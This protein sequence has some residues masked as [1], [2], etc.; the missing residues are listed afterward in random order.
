VSSSSASQIRPISASARARSSPDV[1]ASLR[2]RSIS[3]IA[4]NFPCARR[5]SSSALDAIS[6]LASSATSFS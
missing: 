1:E 4:S 5:T 6:S 3:T 2:A